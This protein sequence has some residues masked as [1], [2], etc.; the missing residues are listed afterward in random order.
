[1]VVNFKSYI[2]CPPSYGG[3]VKNVEIITIESDFG[4]GKKGAKLGPQAF[5]NCFNSNLKNKLPITRIE[6]NHL[7]EE[8]P[9]PGNFAKNIESIF[10][11]Q[12]LALSAIENAIEANSLPWIISG[13]HS[14]GL[15]GISAYRNLYPNNT[16]GV[17]WID[18]HADLHTPFTSPSGNMHGMPLAAALGLRKTA[19]GKNNLDKESMLLWDNLINLGSNQINPKIAPNN[20]VF[21]ELRDLEAEEI[22]LLNSLEIK[23]YTP[24]Q[25][26]AI[27][28][29]QLLEE[30]NAQLSNCDHILVSFD[31]DSLDPTISFGTGTPVPGGLLWEEAVDLLSALLQSPKLIAFETTEINPLLDR[32]NPMEEV[33]AKL[34]E[35]VFEKSGFLN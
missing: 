29:N 23:N 4:A 1:M 31:V 13:D 35:E 22:E 34:I 7:E 33:S 26:K 18:A 25:R 3:F 8:E 9:Y 19:T 16:L 11:V 20:L 32:A 15:A 2:C 21:L 24:E 17:I 5:L 28:L 10:E 6:S 30:I 12:K 14:N 27:G